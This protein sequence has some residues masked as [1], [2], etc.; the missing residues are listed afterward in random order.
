MEIDSYNILCPYC[1]NKCGDVDNFEGCDLFDEESISMECDDCGKKFECRRVVTIDY[2]T[3]KDC[4]LNGEEHEK[5]EYHCKKCDV[6][7][8]NIKDKKKV[9]GK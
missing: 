6:Y 4:G 2:R 1:Q 3:G 9:A 7:N 5:G 8:P